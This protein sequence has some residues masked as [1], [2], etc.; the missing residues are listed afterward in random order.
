V[1]LR[2]RAETNVNEDGDLTV[3]AVAFPVHECLGEIIS[4]YRHLVVEERLVAGAVPVEVDEQ[5]A[6]ELP[7]GGVDFSLPV[8]ALEA[9][10]PNGS[11]SLRKTT[12]RPRIKP[13]F[14]VAHIDHRHSRPHD[15]A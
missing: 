8:A 5:G 9:A 11:G 13:L 1:S 14:F 15:D 10:H 2:R 3:P 12:H 4:F 6:G 7:D